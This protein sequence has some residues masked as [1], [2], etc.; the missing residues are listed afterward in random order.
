MYECYQKTDASILEINPLVIA[1]DKVIALD[2]KFNFDS[3]ALLDKRKS[4]K[5]VILLRR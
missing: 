3:N 2:S 1:D 4:S 5:C